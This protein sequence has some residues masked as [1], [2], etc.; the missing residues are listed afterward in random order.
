MIIEQHEAIY[1][2]HFSFETVSFEMIRYNCEV[3][4]TNIIIIIDAFKVEEFLPVNETKI[5]QK[6]VSV[7]L[8]KRNYST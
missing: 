7:K 6:K 3:V 4:S 5:M 8:F 2:A 1:I